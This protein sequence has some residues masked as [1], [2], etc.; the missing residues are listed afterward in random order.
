MSSSLYEPPPRAW[1]F[2][3]VLDSKFII[4]GGKNETPESAYSYNPLT[5]LWSQL[6]TTGAPTS[7][8]HNGAVVSLDSSSL[9]FGGYDGSSHHNCLYQLDQN[10]NFSEHKFSTEVSPMKKEGCRMIAYNKSL[11]LFGGY[12]DPSYPI[13]P[14]SELISNCTNELHSFNLEEGE[15]V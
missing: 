6:E 13:Q 1:P 8:L 4:Y 5:E 7:K 9:M 14:G 11:L 10:N 2:S 15:R 12:C 3:S